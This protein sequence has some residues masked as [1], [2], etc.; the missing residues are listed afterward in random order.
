[1]N[2]QNQRILI[3]YLNWAEKYDEWLDISLAAGRARIAK[4]TSRSIGA[5]LS[6][7]PFTL[8]FSLALFCR[9][10][11]VLEESLCKLTYPLD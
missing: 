7:L 10:T 11:F 4:F 9:R 6:P 1:M 2:L 3:H 8:H 5:W